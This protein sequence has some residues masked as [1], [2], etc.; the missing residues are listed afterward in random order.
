MD[1][2]EGYITI[3]VVVVTSIIYLMVTHLVFKVKIESSILQN[4][5]NNIQSY[6]ITEGKIIMS[7]KDEKYYVNQLEPKILDAFRTNRFGRKLEDIII[8]QE[9]L[10][11]GDNNSN[12]R[13]SFTDINNRKILNLSTESNCNGI[14]TKVTSSVTLVNELFEL[15]IP[16]LDSL[17]IEDEIKDKLTV[18]IDHISKNVTIANMNIPDTMYSMEYSNYRNI[19]LKKLNKSDYE[20]AFHRDSMESPYIERFNKKDIFFVCKKKE[21]E[22]LNLILDDS[23]QNIQLS[24][25]IYVEGNL[26][27]SSNFNFNGIIIVKNGEISVENSKT[28]KINGLVILDNV[29]NSFEFIEKADI[30]YNNSYIYKFGTYLPGFLQPNIYTIKSN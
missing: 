19:T 21:N 1:K 15:G 23:G 8:S 9:D 24:G 7:L 26:I 3:I 18:L 12:I 27:I 5:K 6:Y 10:D 4:T 22:D 30:L 13:L 29:S 28:V 25:I 2:K 16:L 11:F 14:I 20:L 17:F